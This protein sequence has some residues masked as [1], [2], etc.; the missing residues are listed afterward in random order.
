[1]EVT[2]SDLVFIIGQLHI[3]NKLCE[4]ERDVAIAE[5]DAL[6]AEL[7]SAKSSEVLDSDEDPTRKD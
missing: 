2:N 6:A 5:R 7:A 3:E 1:M 4:A